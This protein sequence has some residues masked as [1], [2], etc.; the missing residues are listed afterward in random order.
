[1]QGE[2]GTTEVGELS[3]ETQTRRGWKQG[4]TRKQTPGEYQAASVR[5]G[6]GDWK[7]ALKVEE[8]ETYRV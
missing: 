5:K 3:N 6:V 4:R 1:M 8:N 7:G 2:R